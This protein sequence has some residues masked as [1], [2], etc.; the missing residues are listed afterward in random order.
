MDMKR[1]SGI[2][3]VL[4]LV[5]ICYAMAHAGSQQITPTNSTDMIARV[6]S[7]LNE[8][9]ASFWT[10][11]EL[12]GWMNS[13]VLDIAARTRALQ[14][15]ENATIWEGVIEYPI[16]SDYIGVFGVIY[17]SNSTT[18]KALSRG[19]PFSL[20]SG[21]GKGTAVNEPVYWAESRGNIMVWPPCNAAKSGNQLVIYLNSRPEYIEEGDN[22]PLPSYLDNALELYVTSRAL[23][24]DIRDSRGAYFGAMYQSEIDRFRADYVDYGQEAKDQ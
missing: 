3:C 7:N 24:K 22:I 1:F 10:D 6:R 4:L 20:V 21:L 18:P 12:L 9:V 19:N 23:H 16:A 14:T 11:A 8:S 5:F 2:A 15:T 17:W 13:G